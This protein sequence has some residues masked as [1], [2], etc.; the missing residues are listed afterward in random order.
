MTHYHAYLELTID[1]ASYKDALRKLDRQLRPNEYTWHIVN[2]QTKKQQMYEG[3]V[4]EDGTVSLD[5]AD[6][7]HIEEICD[8]CDEWEEYLTVEKARKNGKEIRYPSW[9]KEHA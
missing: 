4:G 8:G 9:P 7:E 2:P 5:I 3:F 1:A 6:Y